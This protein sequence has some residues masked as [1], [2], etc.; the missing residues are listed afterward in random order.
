MSNYGAVY[1]EQ[2]TKLLGDMSGK[3]DL[4]GCRSARVD[5]NFR[6]I[7]VICEE[8]RRVPECEYCFCDKDGEDLPDET[9]VFLTVGPHQRAY[10]MK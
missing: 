9:V 8:C 6:I 3:L 1:E 4:R 10:A 7:F 2:F 5:R